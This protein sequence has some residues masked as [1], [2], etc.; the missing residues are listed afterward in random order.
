MKKIGKKNLEKA[1]E[2]SELYVAELCKPPVR[3]IE[4]RPV[5]L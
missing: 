1:G 5:E 3:G 2:E 4:T